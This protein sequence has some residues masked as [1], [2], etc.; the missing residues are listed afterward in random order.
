MPHA[1]ATKIIIASRHEETPVYRIDP[2]PFA[3][4]VKAKRSTKE[5]NGQ[6]SLF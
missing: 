2:G 1:G 5:S 3:V 4:R 6:L